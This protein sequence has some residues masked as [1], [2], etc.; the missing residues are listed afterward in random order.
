MET[1]V[2]LGIWDDEVFVGESVDNIKGRKLLLYTDGLNEAEN[3]A[4]DQFGDDRLAQEAKALNDLKSRETIE[5][6]VASVNA[7][8]DGAEPNDDLTMVCLKLI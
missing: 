6:V 1:N 2:P 7:F 4:Q 8:R 5:K 3:S